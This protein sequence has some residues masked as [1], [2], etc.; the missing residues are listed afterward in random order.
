[1]RASTSRVDEGARAWFEARDGA[2]RLDATVRVPSARATMDAFMDAVREMARA[3]A[4][5]A[6]RRSIER[7]AEARAANVGTEEAVVETRSASAQA[8]AACEACERRERELRAVKRALMER[9]RAA[10]VVGKTRGIACAVRP[11]PAVG[12]RAVE[13][14]RAEAAGR[15]AVNASQRSRRGE[16]SRWGSPDRVG[17][18]GEDAGGCFCDAR[19]TASRATHGG[20]REEES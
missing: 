3:D 6:R 18:A 5:E 15:G 19:A 13:V 14:R 4:A 8:E 12:V 2:T 7:A 16:G 1:M 10:R 17:R 9:E 11:R 20:A